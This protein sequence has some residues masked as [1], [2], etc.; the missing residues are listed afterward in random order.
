MGIVV[1]KYKDKNVILCVYSAGILTHW[2]VTNLIGTYN[3]LICGWDIVTKA[4]VKK[5]AIFKRSL[6]KNIWLKTGF[7]TGLWERQTNFKL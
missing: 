2:Q 7:L 6:K 4:V 5:I 1:I 3:W